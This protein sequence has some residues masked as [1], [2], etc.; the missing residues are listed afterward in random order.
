MPAADPAGKPGAD[1]PDP[2]DGEAGVDGT[3]VLPGV[4][5]LLALS[6]EEIRTLEH[7]VLSDLL[8]ELR[9]RA[10]R[11]AETLWGFSQGPS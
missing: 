8:A 7:P 6:L 1:P 10:G 9:E 3:V 5:D 4:P 2:E 11:P